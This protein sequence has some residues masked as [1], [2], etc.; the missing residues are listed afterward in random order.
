M[1][2]SSKPY[3]LF[4]MFKTKKKWSLVWSSSDAPFVYRCLLSVSLVMAGRSILG[5][6]VYFALVFLPFPFTLH[7]T[8]AG[9]S[10][11]KD[12]LLQIL[13]RYRPKC[14]FCCSPLLATSS[15]E[16]ILESLFW[17]WQDGNLG[18]LTGFMGL[19]SLIFIW[20]CFRLH[21]L[22]YFLY[23]LCMFF[24]TRCMF[25][26]TLV[27]LRSL[28]HFVHSSFCT[29]HPDVRFDHSMVLL[30]VLLPLFPNSLTWHMLR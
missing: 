11:K 21:S 23:I 12:E 22:Q 26:Y 4:N 28:H 15:V 5:S 20:R 2:G 14:S 27:F 30:I 8:W 7:L 24:H 6:I 9:G 10:P 25:F 16:E 29:Q 17:I 1:S 18:N 13:L 19:D 3:I